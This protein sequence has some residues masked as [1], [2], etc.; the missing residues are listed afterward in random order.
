MDKILLKYKGSPA[1]AEISLEKA[2]ESIK[3]GREQKTLPEQYLKEKKDLM[4]SYAT[5]IFENM[6]EEIAK[7]VVPY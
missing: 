7:V 3:V 5:R 6:I 1:D 2:V 4:D